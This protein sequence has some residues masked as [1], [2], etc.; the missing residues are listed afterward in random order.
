MRYYMFNKPKGCITACSDP[1]HKTV[2]EYIPPAERQGLFPVGRLDKDTEGFLILTDDG[3][4]SNTVS[5]PSSKKTKTY[6]LYAEGEY[7]PE[8]LNMLE[9]GVMMKGEGVSAPSL[10]KY[11]GEYRLSDIVSLFPEQRSRILHTKLGNKKI[12]HVEI[13]VTEGKKH[14]IKKMMLAVGMKVV[15]LERV[16]ISGVL[17]D[18]SLERGAYRPL[19]DEELRSILNQ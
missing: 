9:A 12:H 6:R 17:L 5:S 1:R 10:A 3:A 16:A 15:Y 7:S 18:A 2:M 8:K 19:A 4:F 11:L 13:T 14:Q